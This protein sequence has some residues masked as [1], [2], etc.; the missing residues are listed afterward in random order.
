MPHAPLTTERN[1]KK[2]RKDITGTLKEKLRQ[3]SKK[4]NNERKCE[5]CIDRSETG[6][7]KAQQEKNIK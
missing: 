6:P 3:R 7:P 5:V 2:I 1:K 4:I